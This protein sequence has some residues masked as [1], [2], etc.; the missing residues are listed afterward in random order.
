MELHHI[1]MTA[2]KIRD[3]D[4]VAA[5]RIMV[6]ADKPL[7]VHCFHGSDR[8]G[9]VIAMYRMVVQGWPREKAVAEFMDPQYGHHADIFPNIRHYLETVDIGKIR[10]QVFTSPSPRSGAR[11]AP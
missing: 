8:T 6:A 7:L 5:L 3:E 9:A 4:I 1:R 2:G 10:R 11:A